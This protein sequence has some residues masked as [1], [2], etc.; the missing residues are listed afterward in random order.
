[1]AVTAKS[2][3]TLALRAATKLDP[4]DALDLVATAA[5]E[6][7]GGGA[8]LL[9]TGLVNVGAQVHVERRRDGHLALSIT[10]GKRLVELCTFSARATPQNGKT[11]LQVGGLETYK[12]SQ[13]KFLYLIPIGPKLIMGYDPYKRFLQGVATA[14]RGKD[15]GA[16]VQIDV[17]Q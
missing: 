1:M 4:A 8:S 3:S 10:S 6:V 12:T 9:T 14:L 17:T 16:A 7:K 15:P 13:S 11:S 2:R 5:G